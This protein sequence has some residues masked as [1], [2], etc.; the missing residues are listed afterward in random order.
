MPVEN[1]AGRAQRGEK[2]TATDI[3]LPELSEDALMSS[4]GRLCILFMTR[5]CT[6]KSLCIPQDIKLL[7]QLSSAKKLPSFVTSDK[8]K[9]LDT[10]HI[11]ITDPEENVLSLNKDTSEEIRKQVVKGLEEGRLCSLDVFMAL[12]IRR[13]AIVRF[14]KTLVLSF[15]QGVLEGEKPSPGFAQ[16]LQAELALQRSELV[17]DLSGPQDSAGLET[18]S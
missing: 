5:R 4:G 17:G 1:S 11:D 12:K 15:E 9:N 10:P 14:L 2:L 3:L 18:L 16:L 6:D 13:T 7:N 8:V